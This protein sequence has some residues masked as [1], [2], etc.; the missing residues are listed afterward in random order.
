M[1]GHTSKPAATAPVV[2]VSKSTADQQNVTRKISRQASTASLFGL[3]SSLHELT[4]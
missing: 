1:A 2:G 4:K 3:Q